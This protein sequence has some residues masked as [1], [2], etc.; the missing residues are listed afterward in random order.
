M[1]L[2]RFGKIYKINQLFYNI[3]I[4]F[5]ILNFLIKILS[6]QFLMMD[7]YAFGISGHR[8]YAWNTKLVIKMFIVTQ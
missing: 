6:Q 8:N 5:R 3:E 2:S 7:F 1:E 4:K